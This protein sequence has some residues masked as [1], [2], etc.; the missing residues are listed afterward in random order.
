MNTT[1]LLIPADLSTPMS[2]VTVRGTGDDLNLQDL[3]AA[4]GCTLVDAVRPDHS[5][6]S[7]KGGMIWVD[8]EGL[9]KADPQPNLRASI[10]AGRPLYG[11]AVYTINA[12]TVPFI[13]CSL[14]AAASVMGADSRLM[15]QF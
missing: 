13:P 10:L 15:R 8:D 2:P 14:D 9:L 11:N 4:I 3:Y 1:A 7:R 6:F 5:H 12:A